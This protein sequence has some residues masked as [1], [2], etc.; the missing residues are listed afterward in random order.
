[1]HAGELTHRTGTTA[2]AYVEQRS[3]GKN[4]DLSQ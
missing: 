1:M 4:H 2:Q 3:N